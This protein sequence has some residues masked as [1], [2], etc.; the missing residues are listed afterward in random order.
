MPTIKL[1]KYEF[2]D[3]FKVFLY[4]LLVWMF[5]SLIFASLFN[6]L[7]AQSAD[8]DKLMK[9]LPAE[10]LQAFNISSNGYL[11]KVETFLSGQ[12][13]SFF[14]LVGSIMGL[15]MGVG[16]LGSK[17]ENK[18]ITFWF[19]K[20]I[21]RTSIYI[22]KFL[23]KSLLFTLSNALIGLIMYFS[24]Y[25]LTDQ[26]EISTTYFVS[27]LGATTLLHVTSVS[28]G[29]FLGVVIEKSKTQAIG[30]SILTL[31]WFLNALSSV[32]N[33]PEWAKYLSVF[34]FLNLTQ[35][36]DDFS[37]DIVKFGILGA[38]GLVFLIV[39]VLVFRRKSIFI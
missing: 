10:M 38:V 20:N 18:T 7:Q 12:F 21:S 14:S 6:S 32:G 16:T 1:V 27:L 37:L 29:M 8:L 39:G 15:M 31:S 28:I 4:W 5:V 23:V 34:Y 19:S 35:I 33:Y 25:Y 9:S 3:T 26:K 36:R 11:S 2:I 13:A 22:T 30:I 24:F 17:I